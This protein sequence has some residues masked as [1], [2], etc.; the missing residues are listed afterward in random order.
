[1]RRLRVYCLAGV[2]AAVVATPA[3]A[4]NRIEGTWS[5]GRGLVEITPAG[6]AGSYKGVIVRRLTF[7]KC[8]HPRGERMWRIF[9]LEDGTYRGS[10]VNYRTPD[11]QEDPGAPAI[12]RVRKVGR[13][14]VLDFCANDPGTEAPSGFGGENC[15]TL[16]RAAPARDLAQI[17]GSGKVLVSQRRRSGQDLCV[18]G[19]RELRRYGCVRRRGR[20]VHQFDV[21]LKRK[22]RRRGLVPANARLKSVKFRLDR[23]AARADRR[24]PFRFSVKASKLA[25][26]PHALVADALL[27]VPATKSEPK[28]SIRKKVRFKFDACA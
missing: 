21:V 4:A 17:C 19:P 26:G 20:I 8:A 23:R 28:R 24:R 6:T 2:L 15:R 13:T 9:D 22:S 10:H 1:M 25:A 3:E 7:A 14:Q 12:W 27:R 18:V 11:C 16:K 5:F